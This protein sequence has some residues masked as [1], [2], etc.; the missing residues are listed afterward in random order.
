MSIPKQIVLVPKLIE[1]S[2][3]VNAVLVVS[4]TLIMKGIVRIPKIHK[5]NARPIPR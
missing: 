3:Q 1:V 2:E 5:N 4:I